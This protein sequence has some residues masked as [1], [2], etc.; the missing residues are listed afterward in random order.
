MAIISETTWEAWTNQAVTGGAS[1]SIA[2]ICTA[3]DAAI[4][5]MLLPY[6][7]EPVTITDEIL[8]APPTR[9]LILGRRPVR[10]LTSVYYRSDADGV[11][12][13]FSSDY[14]LTA[15]TD[16]ALLVDDPQN[17]WSQSGIVRR[18]GGNVWGA[19][20]YRQ[21][22]ALASR[23]EGVRGSVKVTY[24]AGP[25]AVPSDIEAAA[26]MAVSLLYNRKEQGAPF[27]SES[28]N[29]RSQSIASQHTADAAVHSPEVLALLRPYM[30]PKFA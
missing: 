1:T 21:P 12:A 8:D 22:T 9:D 13:N 24:T 18:L 6:L 23:L 29:G 3:V 20:W 19:G 17:G 25:S 26:V 2:A 16:Y 15:G 14:L 11:V 28:W 7:P 30:T 4:K 27:G 5:R 10:A